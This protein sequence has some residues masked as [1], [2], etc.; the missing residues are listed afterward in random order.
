MQDVE[1]NTLA[2]LD[3]LNVLVIDDN[4]LVHSV[5]K[6]SLFALGIKEVRCVQNAYYGLRL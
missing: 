2:Q 1:K 6:A 4:L 3:Q 5:L